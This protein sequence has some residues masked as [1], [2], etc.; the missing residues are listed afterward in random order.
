MLS[1]FFYLQFN[2]TIPFQILIQVNFFFHFVCHIFC[3]E[4]NHFSQQLLI[5]LS[6]LQTIFILRFSFHVII[7]F[8]LIN[9]Q[10]RL[11]FPFNTCQ[12]TSNRQHSSFNNLKLK[13]NFLM[14]YLTASFFKC[15]LHIC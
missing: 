14:T 8:H 13:H 2:Q 1:I 6:Y 7:C 15:F 4:S 9:F 10:R 11:H 12:S 5:Q 3:F